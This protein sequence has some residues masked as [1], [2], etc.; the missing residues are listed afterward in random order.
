M[1]IGVWL[2]GTSLDFLAIVCARLKP[3]IHLNVHEVFQE[4]TKRR[5]G[6]R[7]IARMLIAVHVEERFRDSFSQMLDSSNQAINGL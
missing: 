2:G 6:L 1:K 4:D 7:T 3:A 5:D